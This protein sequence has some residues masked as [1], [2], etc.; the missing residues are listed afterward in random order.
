MGGQ[1][2]T[3][4]QRPVQNGAVTR[5]VVGPS[6]S[7]HTPDAGIP[8]AMVKGV[9]LP[10]PVIREQAGCESTRTVTGD[11]RVEQTES[12]HDNGSIDVPLVSVGASDS[13]VRESSS[14]YA[15]SRTGKVSV[16]TQ[17]RR[18]AEVGS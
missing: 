8:E 16:E 14:G 13:F 2:G 18:Q 7:E 15:A 3:A 11:F 9:V 17:G 6:P 10:D 12:S 1:P 4:G 5:Q